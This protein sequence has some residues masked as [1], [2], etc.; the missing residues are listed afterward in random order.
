M[1]YYA[2]CLAVGLGSLLL[3]A[4]HLAGAVAPSDEGVPLDIDVRSAV[5]AKWEGF[6]KLA[7]TAHDRLYGLASVSEVPS[8]AKLVAPVD[9]GALANHLRRAM[10]AHGF[11]EI[12]AGERPGIVLTVTCGRGFLRNPYLAEAMV[13][14]MAEGVTVATIT[15]PKQ[16]MRQRE[17]AAE[18]K[19]QKA[20]FEKRYIAV[21]AWQYPPSPGEKPNQIW[22]TVMVVDNPDNRDLNL[23]MPAKLAAGVGY[24]DRDIKE[25]EVTINSTMSAGT[26]TLGPLNLIEEKTGR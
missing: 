10:A 3:P 4:P 5:E 25:G 26:V 15:S 9:R 16:A 19:R 17:F 6:K 8:A 18:A 2:S 14:D 7:K 22:R 1:Q 12:S 21:T 20:Q 13:N 11:R 23:A 24:F